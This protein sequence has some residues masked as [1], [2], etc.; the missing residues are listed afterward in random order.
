MP[1]VTTP[2]SAAVAA[3]RGPRRALDREV[4]ALAAAAGEH[5]LVRTAPAHRGD[6]LARLFERGLRGPRRARARP[7]GSRGA[8]RGTAASP[9]SPR[10]ASASRPRGRGRRT[11]SG[12]AGHASRLGRGRAA[13]GTGPWPRAFG[14]RSGC[15]CHTRGRYFNHERAEQDNQGDGADRR[16][17]AAV[18]ARR[19][20]RRRRPDWQLD[21]RTR[22]VGRLGVAQAREVL[23]QAR[24]PEPKQPEPVR[25]AS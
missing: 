15:C 3:A 2:S 21:E 20:G 4:V 22:S 18:A 24:P 8:R 6:R 17:P 1:V 11:S 16:E 10:A 7:T 5:D 25:K 19:V 14:T 12:T 13:S 9:R 23:R